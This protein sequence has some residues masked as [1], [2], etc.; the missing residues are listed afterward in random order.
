[1]NNYREDARKVAKE[2]RWTFFRF[3]PI[4]ITAIVIL[5]ILGFG[6]NSIGLFGKVFVERKVFENSYQRSEGLKS[7]AALQEATIQQIEGMLSNPNLDSDTRFNLEA[8]LNA[9][10]LRLNV[11]RGQQ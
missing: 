11:I 6:L 4:T 2:T 5:S 9:A 8:Q 1:M 3:L 7:G 10:R